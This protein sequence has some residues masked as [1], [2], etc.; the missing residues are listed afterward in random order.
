MIFLGKGEKSRLCNDTLIKSAAAFCRIFAHRQAEI[1]CQYQNLSVDCYRCL[2]HGPTSIAIL[3]SMM[4][5]GKPSDSE[6][7]RTAVRLRG[8]KVRFDERAATLSQSG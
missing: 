4:V 6:Q 3:R 2:N 1:V 8:R 7:C 5:E